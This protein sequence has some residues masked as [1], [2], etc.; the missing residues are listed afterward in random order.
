MGTRSDPRE[1]EVTSKEP[2]SGTGVGGASC[3][4][5]LLLQ[6]DSSPEFMSALENEGTDLEG[7]TC[8]SD[9]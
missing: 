1:G 9:T 3:D 6:P 5:P 4:P 8:R 7:N 2:T